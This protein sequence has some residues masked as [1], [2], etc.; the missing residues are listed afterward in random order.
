[1]KI[2]CGKPY[3]SFPALT[4]PVTAPPQPKSRLLLWYGSKW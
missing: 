4:M 2:H 1:M 3:F